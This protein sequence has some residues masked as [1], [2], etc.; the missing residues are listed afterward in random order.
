MSAAASPY[1]PMCFVL[2]TRYSFVNVW[3]CCWPTFCA[4]LTAST[5]PQFHCC[6]GQIGLRTP[7]RMG[8]PVLALRAD[9]FA[10]CILHACCLVMVEHLNL[11]SHELVCIF[12]VI[13]QRSNLR[14]SYHPPP[15]GTRVVCKTYRPSITLDG[16]II[17]LMCLI[18]GDWCEDPLGFLNREIASI[19]L[20]GNIWVSRW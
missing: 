8:C 11:Y 5:N 18:N 17:L 9:V 3:N 16:S 14:A 12:K 10:K 2:S 19:K 4:F 6:Q 1:L 20:S 7:L 13:S 15:E